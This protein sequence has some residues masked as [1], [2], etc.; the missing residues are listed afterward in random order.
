MLFDNGI[1]NYK[2]FDF[3]PIAVG[4]AKKNNEKYSGNFVVDNA[5]TSQLYN[6]D[7]NIVVILE[8]LEHI[9]RDFLVLN[10]ISKNT[11]I[12]FSVPNFNSESHVRWFNSKDDIEKRYNNII[13]INKIK[14]I[15]LSP[16]SNM[17]YLVKGIK[18]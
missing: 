6:Y 2:G 15:I 1:T 10:K 4:L 7:Y 14:D 12:I 3:S 13:K 11:S 8:V 9:E 17:I 5:Y 16:T 18:R